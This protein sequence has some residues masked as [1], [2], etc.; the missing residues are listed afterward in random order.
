VGLIS[1]FPHQFNLKILGLSLFAL[2]VAGLPFYG[3][4]SSL[5]ALTLITDYGRLDNAV[6]ALQEHLAAPGEN[7]PLEPDS[8]E[9]AV[10]GGFKTS[11]MQ[12]T[13]AV[14]REPKIKTYGFQVTTDL[15]LIELKVPA[16]RITSLGL[17]IYELGEVPVGFHL[18]AAQSS[19]GEIC[20]MYFL[21]P[22]DLERH[23][24]ERV[25]MAEGLK[26]NENVF[27][28]SPS[29]LLHFQGPHYGDRY[30][31]AEGT[32]KTLAL[33]SVPV[34]LAACSHS[35]VYLV[36]PETGAQEGERCLAKVFEVPARK[37]EASKR[38]AV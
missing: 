29:E 13:M 31:I 1:L 5:S 36:L 24:L 7:A 21:I 28:V 38:K 34:L 30:G 27:V 32:F 2:G 9:N 6:A 33:G 11:P 16:Q 22:Q 37:G 19:G 18:V 23:V 15:S 3:M 20:R 10:R 35:C 12:Q 4:A 17:T 14:Y 8:R 25:R 26:E